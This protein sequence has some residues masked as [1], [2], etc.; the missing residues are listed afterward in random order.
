MYQHNRSAKPFGSEK[1][2]GALNSMNDILSSLNSLPEPMARQTS[3][4]STNATRQRYQ[5]KFR[6]DVSKQGQCLSDTIK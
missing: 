4:A 5:G 6:C 1:G 2:G 3:P